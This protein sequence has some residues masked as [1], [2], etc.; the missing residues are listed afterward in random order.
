MQGFIPS[1]NQLL[2]HTGLGCLEHLG[3]VPTWLRG[4]WIIVVYHLLTSAG[5]VSLSGFTSCHMF[6]PVGYI[7]Y[8]LAVT[9]LQQ[10][11]GRLK[12]SWTGFVSLSVCQS[13]QT[14]LSDLSYIYSICLRVYVH[15]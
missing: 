15:T 1:L 12:K 2:V 3:S 4:P 8:Q 11:G 7:W 5:Y 13:S 14:A 6:S 9:A 10:Q